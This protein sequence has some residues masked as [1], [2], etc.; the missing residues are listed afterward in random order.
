MC[1]IGRRHVDGMATQS[2]GF[3]L[4]RQNVNENPRGRARASYEYPIEQASLSATVYTHPRV[5]A[6]L[7]FWL[8][9][10]CA[11]GKSMNNA[12]VQIVAL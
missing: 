11:A 4:R 10:H 2:I 6:R 7:S 12:I 9:R 8:S 3:N 1:S 5:Y